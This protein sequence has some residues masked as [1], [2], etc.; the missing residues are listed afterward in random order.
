MDLKLNE[1]VLG[2]ANVTARGA[3]RGV[4][5]SAVS[6]CGCYRATVSAEGRIAVFDT[7]ESGAAS[8][9]WTAELKR[10]SVVDLQF[11][12]NGFSLFALTASGKCF[13]VLLERRYD[14]WSNVTRNSKV[15][16]CLQGGDGKPL[17]AVLFCQASSPTHAIA[18]FAGDS[19]SV[20]LRDFGNDTLNVFQANVGAFV[21][22]MKFLNATTLAVAGQHCVEVWKLCHVLWRTYDQ[23]NGRSELL[24]RGTYKPERSLVVLYPP[25][26]GKKVSGFDLD[27]ETQTLTIVWS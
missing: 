15:E 21:Y 12:H 5:C 16:H 3:E 8:L 1:I 19:N 25:L 9:L 17:N 6:A 24:G 13:H 4:Q 20:Y 23:V 7:R 22:R 27:G 26:P 18:A 11:G 2:G 10:E 14:S